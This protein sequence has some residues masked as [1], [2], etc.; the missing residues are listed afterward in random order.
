MNKPI[1]IIAC[2]ALAKELVALKQVNQWQQLVLQ[3]LPADLHNRPERIP[4]AV[5]AKLI[6]A[7]ERFASVFVA[8]GDCGT[9]GLLDKVLDK[10]DVQRISGAHCYEF[11]AGS[12]AF[13]QLA[14]AE[15]GTLYLTDFLTRHFERLIWPGLRSGKTSGVTADVFW[16]L[17]KTGLSRPD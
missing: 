17:S 14:E 8:Y 7:Q 12:E 15:P 4:A 6:A 16:Q 5:E 10:Y 9:G 2:G 11:Y 3:C 1:L 13:Q